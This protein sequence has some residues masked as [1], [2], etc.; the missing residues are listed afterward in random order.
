[1]NFRVLATDEQLA[2]GTDPVGTDVRPDEL[3]LAV[4]STRNQLALPVFG[5]QD[6]EATPSGLRHEC[7][8][9]EVF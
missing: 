7:G 2:I 5:I 4:P 8:V 6:E 9:H 1:M 3:E